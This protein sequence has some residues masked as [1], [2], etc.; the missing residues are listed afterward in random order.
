MNKLQEEY[1]SKGLTILSVTGQGRDVVD[2]FVEEL[3]PIYPIITQAN[4]GAYS[5][6]GVP[7]AYLIAADGTV[8]W[9]GHPGALGDDEIEALL[10][11][12]EKEN[13]VSSWSFFLNKQLP[14]IPAKLASARKDLDKKKF[15]SA[16]KKVESTVGKLEG[17]DKANGEKL[18]EWIS[19]RGTEPLDKAANLVREGEVYAGYVI[20]E[21]IQT[22]FKGHDMAK[23]AK[24]AAS[25][26][27]KDKG[28]K[29]EIKAAEKLAEVK[30]EMRSERKPEDQLD[31]LKPLLSK[32]YAETK[33]GKAAAELAKKIEAKI[34]K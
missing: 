22:L 34:V 15:G 14:A 2:G 33:A 29:L 7:Q 19:V 32:K 27:M 23:Q 4:S 20:Y 26:L 5:T 28:N 10:K 1:E 12:V 21:E 8:A 13:R 17:E 16:L 25:A 3:E 9:E 6:G 30:S 31:C 18:Q 11:D 24:A